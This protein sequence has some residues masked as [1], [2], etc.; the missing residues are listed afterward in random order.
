MKQFLRYVVTAALLTASVRAQVERILHHL[1]DVNSP[2]V[3]VA[4]HRADW[5]NAPENSL[6]AIRRAVEYGCRH[7]RV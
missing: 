5:R 1:H 2:V 6:A 7:C 3:L 4:A